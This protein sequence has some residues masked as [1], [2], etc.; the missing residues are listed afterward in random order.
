MPY[1]GPATRKNNMVPE[2]SFALPNSRQFFS[3]IRKS[4]KINPGNKNPI[5]PLVKVAKAEKI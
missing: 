2:S 1:Q 5:G 4:T 3:Q